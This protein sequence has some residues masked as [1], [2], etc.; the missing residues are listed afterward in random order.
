M[1]A[2]LKAATLAAQKPFSMT[3]NGEWCPSCSYNFLHSS[4]DIEIPAMAGRMSKTAAKF[5]LGVFCLLVLY[6]KAIAIL[7]SFAAFF[8]AFC[9]RIQFQPPTI[10][11]PEADCE[12]RPLLLCVVQF[13]PDLV[14]T[15]PCCLCLPRGKG[16]RRLVRIQHFQSLRDI[17]FI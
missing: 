11:V 16:L 7:R 14:S 5:F 13:T 17:R 6:C 3:G 8:L 2:F 15:L 4:L 12:S 9:R 1:K 10:T